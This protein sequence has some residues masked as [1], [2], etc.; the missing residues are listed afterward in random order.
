MSD[1]RM[2][3]PARPLYRKLALLVSVVCFGLAGVLCVVPAARQEG[4]LSTAICLFVG[5]VMLTIGR[6]GFWPRPKR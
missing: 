1:D 6:T 5:F 3:S 4:F 2:K